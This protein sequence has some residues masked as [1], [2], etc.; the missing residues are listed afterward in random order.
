MSSKLEGESGELSFGAVALNL[1]VTL[2]PPKGLRPIGSKGLRI[3]GEMPAQPS[4]GPARSSGGLRQAEHDAIGQVD[5]DSPRLK[6][7]RYTR[8]VA[9]NLTVTLSPPKGLRPIGS[10]GLR[11]YGEMPA[12][13][14]GG[15]A[16]SSGGP[17]RKNRWASAGSA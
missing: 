12:Q 15:P 17:A 8:A 4:G 1:T 14:S 3:Y 6:G 5:P 9:L 13:P 11:I 7:F 10:K 16:R 2:S